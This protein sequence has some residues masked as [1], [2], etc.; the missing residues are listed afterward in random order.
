MP[1]I[2]KNIIS[3]VFGACAL[4]RI[5]AR[6]GR[7]GR[8]RCVRACSA[9]VGTGRAGGSVHSDLWPLYMRFKPDR[10]QL[11]IKGIFGDILRFKPDRM[12]F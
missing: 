12:L 7:G 8:V 3:R 4:G 2:T 1:V 11:Q 10:T 6:P 5:R 9:R